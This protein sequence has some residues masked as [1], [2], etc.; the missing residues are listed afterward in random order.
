MTQASANVNI[1]I[2]AARKAA[3]SL[4]RDFGEVENLQV[5]AKGPGDF[6]SRAD[7]KAEQLIR[8]ELTEARPN[9][10]WLGEE[11]ERGQGRGPDPALDRRSRSTARPNFLHGL[12]HWAISIGLEHKGEIVAGVVY[13]PVKDEMFVAEKGAG[14]YLNDRR[15]RVSGRRDMIEMIFATGIPFGGQDR[16]AA[17][18][19]R[20][21]GADA[22]D[23][24]HPPLG[25][26]VARPRLCRGR[27]VRRLLGARAEPLGR[28]GGAPP[29]AR[30]RR[31][32]RHHRGRGQPDRGRQPHRRQRQCLRGPRARVLRE[33]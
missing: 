14:A 4:L 16:A 24:R 1:M 18:P 9:Y 33:A 26:G 10:G 5:S 15:L 8:D 27:P 29:G 22:A 20:A 2:K 28:G 13:D 23:R 11:S 25:L 7:I 21:R 19:A 32:R 17:D 31:L 30:G 6:V 12:P 3:R